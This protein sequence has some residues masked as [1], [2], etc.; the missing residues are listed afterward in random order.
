MSDSEAALNCRLAPLL[1]RAANAG[2]LNG[3]VPRHATKHTCLAQ[4]HRGSGA[5]HQRRHLPHKRRY[6]HRCNLRATVALATLTTEEIQ[7]PKPYHDMGTALWMLMLMQLKTCSP[8]ASWA[9]PLCP[10]S[11][12]QT[13]A[14]SAKPHQLGRVQNETRTSPSVLM[15]LRGS[16][17][18]SP[19]AQKP[20]APHLRSV[21]RELLTVLE[22]PRQVLLPPMLLLPP[23]MVSTQQ[24]LAQ[25]VRLPTALLQSTVS[26][27]FE[28]CQRCWPLIKASV[29][30]S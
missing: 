19:Q 2:E 4:Q 1:K 3:P 20:C 6:L 11:L 17:G 21:G 22:E 12:L 25:G 8:V 27:A 24:Q 15:Q 26:A 9:R 23:M 29:H 14:Q 16:N 5:V 7:S 10:N 13:L 30:V 18:Q 28:H